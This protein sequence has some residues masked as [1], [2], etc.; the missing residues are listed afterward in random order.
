MGLSKKRAIAIDR[1]WKF[2]LVIAKAATNRRY[3]VSFPM[4]RFERLALLEKFRYEG[5]A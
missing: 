3:L 2:R 5:S 4:D 1:K